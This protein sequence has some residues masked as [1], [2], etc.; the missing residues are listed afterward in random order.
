MKN[1]MNQGVILLGL[2]WILSCCTSSNQQPWMQIFN[3]SDM[4][5]WEIREGS[6][7]AW[8]ENGLM[9]SQQ[10][11]S[12]HFSYLVYKEELNDSI[13]EC[14]VKIVGTLNSGILIR[15]ISD[16]EIRN[17][18]IHGFQMEIDQSER[19]WTGGIYEEGGRKWLTPLTGMGEGESE[20]L[21]AY[22][23]SDWNHYRVE[24]IAD[25]FKIWTNGVPTSHLIDSKTA[26]GMVGFQVH[27][28]NP[29]TEKGFV[30]VKSFQIITENPARYSKKI[31]LPAKYRSGQE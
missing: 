20:A 30:K 15:G 2:L 29:N 9:V 14:E 8:L 16:P 11:D 3:G 23:V 7:E 28:L 6:V 13:L 31:A 12:L 1:K 22:K 21:N 10:T 18:I 17:G 25:T 19:R 27:R 24:A 26:K 5:E 4:D